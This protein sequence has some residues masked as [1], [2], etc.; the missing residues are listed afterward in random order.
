MIL[1][2]NLGLFEVKN[3]PVNQMLI[4][5]NEHIYKYGIYTHEYIFTHIAVCM[6]KY[7]CMCFYIIY[8]YY[9]INLVKDIC[10]I[11]EK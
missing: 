2:V 7:I 4:N 10:V 3:T 5:I 8:T 1:N 11:K 9:A 6:Y